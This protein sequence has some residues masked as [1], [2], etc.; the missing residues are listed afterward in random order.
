M[1]VTTDFQL[2]PD[3]TTDLCTELFSFYATWTS[4]QTDLNLDSFYILVHTVDV[5][6]GLQIKQ[7][8]TTNLYTE[9]YSLHT[10]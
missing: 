5:T 7:D 8:I 6:A 3:I 10:T 2:K 9:L 1:D 4:Q